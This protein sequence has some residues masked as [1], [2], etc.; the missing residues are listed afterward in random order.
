MAASKHFLALACAVLLALGACTNTRHVRTGDPAAEAVLAELLNSLAAA[1]AA[2]TSGNR[3]R[4]RAVL[5]DVQKDV[6]DLQEELGSQPDSAAKT[7]I[8]QAVAAI[9]T[10]V[11]AVDGA[12]AANAAMASGGDGFL[13]RHA[14]HA[15]PG[16]GGVERR[17]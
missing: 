9:E 7:A 3:E 8:V 6:D 1:Q 11:G 2:V 16:S 12:L 15:G 10:A 17:P 5:A 14:R 4:A 13:R